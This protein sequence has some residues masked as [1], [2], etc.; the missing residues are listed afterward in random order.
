MIDN[1]QSILGSSS[2]VIALAIA[3]EL[4]EAFMHLPMNYSAIC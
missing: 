1:T 3:C 2:I 4:C